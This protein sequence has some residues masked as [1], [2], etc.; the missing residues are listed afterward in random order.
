MKKVCCLSFPESHIP[1]LVQMVSALRFMVFKLTIYESMKNHNQ[2]FLNG[3][4]LALGV[5]ELTL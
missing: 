5:Q 1:V 4:S 3:V 2:T